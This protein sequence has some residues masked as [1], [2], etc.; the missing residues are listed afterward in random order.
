MIQEKLAASGTASAA[1]W[2]AASWFIA[3]NDIL[4]L[5]GTVAAI[6]AALATA[7]Y[8]IRKAHQKGE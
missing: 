1:V 3:M 4:Q 6:I 5:V 8:Y 7:Y 2:T